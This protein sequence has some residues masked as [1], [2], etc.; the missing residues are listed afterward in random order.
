MTLRTL[1]MQLRF[2][3]PLTLVLIGA[4]YLAVPLL[5]RVTLRWFDRDLGSR[6]SL[7]ANALSD[8]IAE[9]VRGGHPE[10]LRPLFDR[11]VQ[12]ERLVAI[13][14]CG[15]SGRMLVTTAAFPKPIDCTEAVLVS[16]RSQPRFQLPGGPVRVSMHDITYQPTSW[17]APAASAASPAEQGAAEDETPFPTT[18]SGATPSVSLE[19][20]M[21]CR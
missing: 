20:P 21:S 2:L 7:I 19:P 16:S 9:A 15:E 12:D 13:G 3:V 11:T 14:L 6:G 8:S 4:A 17:P 10:R 1:R 18:A 5:D